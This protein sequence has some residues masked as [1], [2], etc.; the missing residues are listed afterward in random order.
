MIQACP[1]SFKRIDANQ[2]RVH[3]AVITA[4][5]F[6]FVLGDAMWVMPL[7]AYDFA[8]RLFASPVY[9]PLVWLSR[10]IKTCLGIGERMTDAAPKFF[11]AWLGLV[12]AVAIIG[13]AA[14]GLTPY[15]YAL[16][17]VFALCAILEAV[18]DYC[19]G[20]KIYMILRKFQRI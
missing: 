5:L 3:A 2:V 14:A 4:L 9:S 6:V 12:M 18:F 19:I 10:E 11:A 7:I 20:C 8:M 13:L 15:V 1:I 17:A 16:T